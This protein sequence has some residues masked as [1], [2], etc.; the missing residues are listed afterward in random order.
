MDRLRVGVIGCGAIAQIM[1]LPHL[2]ELGDRFEIAALCDADERRL[3]LVADRYGVH[4]RSTSAADLM[5]EALDAVLVLS[6][7][8]HADPVVAALDA[9]KHVFVE[10]P[11]AYTLRGTDDVIAAEGRSGR[12]VMVGMMKRFDPGWQRGL[13]EVRRL[14]DMRLVDV[15]VLHPAGDAY[16]SHHPILGG[17]PP[18]VVAGRPTLTPR[19]LRDA[20]LAAEPRALL[21]E[22]LG[23]DRP[24]LLAAWFLL[25]ASSIHD[26]DLIREALGEPASVVEAAAWADGT[27]HAATLAYP[28]DLRVRYVWTWLPGLRDYREEHSFF[29]PAG[30]VHVVFPSPYLRNE[31]TTVE[32]ETADGEELRTTRIVA[33]FDEAFRRELVAFHECVTAGTPIRTT[34]ADAR[35]NLEVLTAIGRAMR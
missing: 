25:L 10:K 23:S 21:A 6:S 9:G 2:R 3:R 15:R 19:W 28:G 18:S 26:I 30:R 29:A 17:P 8:D 33:S 12:T 35:K 31:P 32:V 14:D 34:V 7:G 22:G 1:H 5:S 13:A 27:S 16:F 20:I 11:V 4:R 24:E